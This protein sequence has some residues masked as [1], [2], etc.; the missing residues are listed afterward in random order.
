MAT[1]AL[2]SPEDVVILLGGIYRIEGV[3]DGT[4]ISISEEEDRWSTSVTVDGRVTRTHKKS[5]LHT[6]SITLSSTSEDNGVFSSWASTDGLLFG[7]VLPLFIKD[8]RGTSLFY[9]PMTW[10]EK[11]PDSGFST[12]VEGRE[13]VLKASGATHIIGGNEGGGVNTNLAAL[14]FIAADFAGLV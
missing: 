14:G 1:I 13:W 7:A 10:I 2:Y 6:V 9:S 4:F 5:P 12:E 8:S 11:V 3:F